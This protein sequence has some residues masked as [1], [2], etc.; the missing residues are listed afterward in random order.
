MS[1]FRTI[2]KYFEIKPQLSLLHTRLLCEFHVNGT[3]FKV[4]VHIQYSKSGFHESADDLM[5]LH[6]VWQSIDYIIVNLVKTSFATSSFTAKELSTQLFIVSLVIT[7]MF[8]PS[9]VD[10]H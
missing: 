10:Q 7:L 1:I 2:I 8:P 9:V 3:R 4:C 5:R 6:N